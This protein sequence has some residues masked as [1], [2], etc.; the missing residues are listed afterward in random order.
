MQLPVTNHRIFIDHYAV[1]GLEESSSAEDIKKAFRRLAKVHHP[2]RSGTDALKFLEIYSAYR[3]LG[4]QSSRRVFDQARISILSEAK[5]KS[6]IKTAGI[7]IPGKRLV[8]PRNVVSLARRGLLRKKFRSHDHRKFLNIDYDLELPLS[9]EEM[10]ST[11]IV[12]IPVIVRNICPDCRGSD[13]NCHACSGRGSYKIGRRVE[14]RI[15][16][17]L[18]DGQIL[19]INLSGF[20]PGPLSYFK[21]KKLLIRI[22]LSRGVLT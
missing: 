17:G 18:T 4:D 16:G 8:Y 3:I 12:S 15:D 6:E 7:R 19:E 1:L 5:S 22:S 20:K 9:R 14:M 10:N 2:D 13:R 11:L 21:K